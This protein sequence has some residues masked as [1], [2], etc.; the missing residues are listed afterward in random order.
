MASDERAVEFVSGNERLARILSDPDRRVQV[1]A[2]TAEMDQIDRRYSD[3]VQTLNG[4]VAAAEATAGAP[5]VTEVL[6]ALQRHLTAA[7]VRDVGVTLAFSDH[8]VTVPIERI[9]AAEQ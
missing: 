6:R 3:A 8:E 5:A 1:D 9:I 4:A 2:I 7:G